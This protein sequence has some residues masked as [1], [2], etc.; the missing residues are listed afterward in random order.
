M[1]SFASISID[2]TEIQIL[3]AFLFIH[4]PDSFT[5]IDSFA[6][7]IKCIT[8][9][10]NCLSMLLQPIQLKLICTFS[11]MKKKTIPQR[12][13]RLFIIIYFNVQIRMCRVRH[14]ADTAAFVYVAWACMCIEI[15][16]FRYLHCRPAQTNR[17]FYFNFSDKNI[18]LS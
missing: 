4:S 10:T 17:I 9:Y 6:S 7:S 5:F 16:I 3:Y 8:H 13:L 11:I 1:M 15:H 12:A 18:V 2:L 14:S